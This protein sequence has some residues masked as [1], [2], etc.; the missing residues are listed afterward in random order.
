MAT[1]ANEVLDR[2]AALLDAAT[3]GPWETGNVAVPRSKLA[4]ERTPEMD[5][6]VAH[7]IRT[8]WIHGQAKA[9]LWIVK[10]W[11]SPYTEPNDWHSFEEPDAELIVAIRNAAPA[12]IRLARAAANL[13]DDPRYEYGR[14]EFNDAIKAIGEVRL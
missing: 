12:L 8:T 6:Q 14:V 7:L 2:L 3:M 5:A 4:M 10:Q 9:K 1:N 13:A 11:Y